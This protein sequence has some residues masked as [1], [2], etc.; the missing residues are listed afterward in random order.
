MR[1]NTRVF[2][3]LGVLLTLLT[4]ITSLLISVAADT[5]RLSGEGEPII[6]P[7]MPPDIQ[8]TSDAW[9]R[10]FQNLLNS[11]TITDFN[12]LYLLAKGAADEVVAPEVFA[13][14]FGST[15]FY[16]WEDFLASEAQE[17]AD[18]LLI[19]GS[20]ADQVDIEWTRA[21]FRR[22]VMIAG[23]T[24][25]FENLREI[26]GDRCVRTPSNLLKYSANAVYVI[27]FVVEI[28]PQ[29]ARYR[30]D[31]ITAELETC[32]DYQADFPYGLTHGT[33]ISP[34]HARP[35][36]FR[37]LVN[38]F[39]SSSVHIDMARDLLGEEQILTLPTAVPEDEEFVHRD[40][41]AVFALHRPKFKQLPM[42]GTVNSR[43]SWTAA[44]LPI[45]KLSTCLG[46]MQ[47]MRWS[48]RRFLPSISP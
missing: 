17:P 10:E 39:L 13:E 26:T 8:A 41:P 43:T 27:T 14:Y 2:M 45:S 44:L 34:L 42:H 6:E 3:G 32:R 7:T 48:L 38:H 31:I 1:R 33:I 19:H 47:P 25:P 35:D 5:A 30:D 22:N 11:R 24:M 12:A 20:M 23:I 37:N 4:L 46:R 40:G 15:A 9:H 16:S 28:E 18:I 21:A 29:Y 36:N